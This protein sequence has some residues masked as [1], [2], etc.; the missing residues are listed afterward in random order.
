MFNAISYLFYC[1]SL[2]VFQLLP[3]EIGANNQKILRHYYI[4]ISLLFFIGFRGFIITDWVEYYK[5]YQI[6]PK[7]QNITPQYMKYLNWDKGFLVY[8]SIVKTITSDYFIFQFISF[9]IDLVIINWFVERYVDEKYYAFAYAAFF[10]FQGLI[11]EVNLLRNS[12]AIMLFLMSLPF[13]EKRNYLFYY[14]LNVLGILFHISSI[15]YLLLPFFINRNFNKK[16][17]LI[18]FLIGNVFFIFHIKWILGLLNLIFSLLGESRLRSLIIGYGLLEKQNSFN[19]GFGYIERTLLFLLVFINHDKLI[20][21]KKSNILF[22]NMFYIYSFIYL[23]FSE[24]YLFVQRFPLLFVCSFWVVV[25]EIYKLLSYKN[26]KIFL[27][28]FFMY[29]MLKIGMQCD[30]L[31]YK[32]TNYLISE[33][34]YERSLELF[35]SVHN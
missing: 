6:V 32:Y 8:A 1:S 10:V 16:F 2:F 23:F 3:K 34:D 9:F 25:P 26:K 14:I 18:I 12:K 30:E 5:F 21:Q 20:Q 22:V 7:I 17:I 29:C 28:I 24:F 4:V 35:R 15:L 13:L 19:L 33:Q 27:A 31:N 11:I